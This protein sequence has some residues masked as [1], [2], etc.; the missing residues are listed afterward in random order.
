[1]HGFKGMNRGSFSMSNFNIK[2]PA[3]FTAALRE[4]IIESLLKGIYY[5]WCAQ[6]DFAMYFPLTF[7]SYF[8]DFLYINLTFKWYSRMKRTSRTPGLGG[9]VAGAWTGLDCGAFL[10]APTRGGLGCFRDP[11]TQEPRSEPWNCRKDPAGLGPLCRRFDGLL[12]RA[13]GRGARGLGG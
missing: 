1:M 6:P 2:F 11:Q 4:Q 5:T 13:R 9:G 8:F 10:R 12:R 3:L 7:E